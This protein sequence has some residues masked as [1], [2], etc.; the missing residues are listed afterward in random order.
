V[1][2][3]SDEHWQTGKQVSKIATEISVNIGNED[4]QCKW[5]TMGTV[6]A[7]FNVAILLTS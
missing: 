7:M 4:N 3:A 5:R 2:T 6:M 1:D